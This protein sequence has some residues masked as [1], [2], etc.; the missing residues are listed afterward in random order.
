MHLIPIWI[1]LHIVR[2]YCLHEFFLGDV[3][4][5]FKHLHYKC[6]LVLNHL[7]LRLLVAHSAKVLLVLELGLVIWGL[8]TRDVRGQG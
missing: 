2:L 4:L 6:L 7:L 8:V 5:L 1:T 3:G